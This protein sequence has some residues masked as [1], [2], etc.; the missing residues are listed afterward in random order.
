[1]PLRRSLVLGLVLMLVAAVALIVVQRRVATDEPPRWQPAAGTTWQWQL[2]AG[3]GATGLDLDVDAEIWDVDLFETTDADLAALQAADRHLVCYLSAGSV[4]D[5][6]DDADDFPAEAVGEPLDGFP[7]E[8][9]LDVRDPRVL[10]VQIARLDR[11]VERGCDG[12]EPDNVDAYDGQSG[13]ELTE[14]NVVIYLHELAIAA[15]ERGLAL[16]LKNGAEIVPD[17]VDVL[18]F[19]VVEECW[20]LDECDA[21]Q[22]FLDADEPVLVAEY[23]ED[24]SPDGVQRH[25][26]DVCPAARESR[27]STLVLPLLLDGSLRVAC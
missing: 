2:Q 12:V 5:F 9:W 25:A 24:E 21:W 14:A 23:P 10:A 20:T 7:D 13:F 26:G 3:A 1:M 4:E 19:A 17:V 11:V 18:D 15:H 8:H 27:A 6:R 16:G 22:P